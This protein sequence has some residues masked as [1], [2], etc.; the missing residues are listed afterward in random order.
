MPVTSEITT[1][2]KK[3]KHTSQ[4]K[5]MQQTLYARTNVSVNLWF[6]NSILLLQFVGRLTRVCVSDPSGNTFSEPSRHFLLN[7]IPLGVPMIHRTLDTVMDPLYAHGHPQTTS[8]VGYPP[9]NCSSSVPLMSSHVS[10]EPGHDQIEGSKSCAIQLLPTINPQAWLLNQHLQAPTVRSQSF[11]QTNFM[12]HSGFHNIHPTVGLHQTP[13]FDQGMMASR[14]LSHI[15]AKSAVFQNACT[16]G[17]TPAG[18]SLSSPSF[19]KAS[20]I[21][22][23]SV[24]AKAII[25]LPCTLASSRDAENLNSHQSFLRHQ[26]QVFQAKEDDVYMH[27][28]GRNKS[29]WMGQVGIRCRHCAHLLSSQRQKGSTYFPA[30][31]SGIYQ[32]AQNM[33]TTHVQNGACPETPDYIKNHF[34]DLMPTKNCSSRGG[35]AYWATTAK[36]L[37]LVET[38]EGIAF[39][40]E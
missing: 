34:V 29:I 14:Q 33:S 23:A 32:A 40:K 10:L 6:E 25:G 18:V 28:R 1:G 7:S 22:S 30:S 19:S 3:A 39:K 27:T 5:L 24:S 31:L 37:G 38:E 4:S 36:T 13:I 8:I 15:P 2:A 12:Y 11:Q 35:R 26:I 9:N 20:S 16:R 21:K 17:E